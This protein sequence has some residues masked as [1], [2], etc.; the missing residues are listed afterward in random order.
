MKQ[1]LNQF[2]ADEN[3]STAIEYSFLSALI[4]IPLVMALGT[5]GVAM[6]Q[7]FSTIGNA[8]IGN[9]SF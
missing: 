3:G 5:V 1:L 4:A 2:I 7:I 8:L 9:P 6:A